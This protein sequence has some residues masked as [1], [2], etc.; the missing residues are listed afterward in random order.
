M[1][2]TGRRRHYK[3]GRREP[4]VHSLIVLAGIVLV[5]TFLSFSLEVEFEGR[6]PWQRRLNAPPE[7]G[8][9]DMAGP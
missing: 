9:S 1:S 2:E 5:W 4:T 3:H 6:G 7:N 8:P